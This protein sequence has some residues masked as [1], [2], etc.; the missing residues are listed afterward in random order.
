MEVESSRAPAGGAQQ[1]PMTSFGVT[2]DELSKLSAEA[3]A[4]YLEQLGGVRLLAPL[5]GT[6]RSV[7]GKISTALRQEPMQ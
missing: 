3:S 7:V 2:A 5:K 1:T 4:E 6:V